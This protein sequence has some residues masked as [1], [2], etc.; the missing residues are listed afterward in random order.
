MV[1]ASLNDFVTSKRWESSLPRASCSFAVSQSRE[2]LVALG[3]GSLFFDQPLLEK[4][5]SQLR[6]TRYRLLCPI[7]F[8][9]CL[10]LH[11]WVW[12][13]KGADAWVMEF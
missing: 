13:D 4:I 11:W 8:G 9:G 7:A 3:T 1:A 6:R 10:S 5:F 12:S 2:S